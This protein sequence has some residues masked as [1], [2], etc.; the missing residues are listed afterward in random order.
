MG[1]PQGQ[2]PLAL[3]LILLHVIPPIPVAIPVVGIGQLFELDNYRLL[4]FCILM[5]AAW[6]L[7]RSKGTARIRGLTGMDIAVF[8]FG[9]VQLFIYVPPDLPDHTILK[10]SATNVLRRGFLFFVDIYVLYFAVSRYCSSRRALVE[11]MGAFCLASA[12]MASVAVF[13]I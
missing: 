11:T 9:L 10:D 7:K 13:E 1:W 5:P 3:Y 4:S 12:M 2:N 8:A 6:R